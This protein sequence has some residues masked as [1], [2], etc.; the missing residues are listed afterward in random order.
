[1]LLILRNILNRV[2][3]T[4]DKCKSFP[5]SNVENCTVILLYTLLLPIIFPY[6]RRHNIR[7]KTVD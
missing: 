3:H 4:V 1:M 2:K 7:G 5:T 6:I